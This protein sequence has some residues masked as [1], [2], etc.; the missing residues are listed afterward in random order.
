M[1]TDR[2][3]DRRMGNCLIDDHAAHLRA[4]GKSERTIE[5]RVEVL[6]RLNT[7]LPFGLAFAATEQIEAWLALP[8]RRGKRR[9]R[10]TTI[11][12]GTHIRG[13]YAWADR[14]G[15]LVGDP[16]MLIGR[17][18]NPKSV[19]KPVTE[20]E[21]ERALKS[22]DPW[23]VAVALAAFAGLRA[24]EIAR[25]RREHVTE[26]SVSVL[27]KG[28][29]PGSVPT[30]AYLW[31][32]VVDRPAGLFVTDRGKPVTGRW[33]SAHARH[34]FDAIGLPEV[35]MHRFRHWYGTT[36]Q[37]LT[38]DIR[39]T[40]ECMRHRQVSSTQGYTLVTGAQR[41]AAVAGLPVPGRASAGI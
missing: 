2:E 31:S 1:I 32:V 6:R 39:I 28:E 5:A 17:P 26:D 35:T 23:F 33:I 22:D 12:F 29:D 7:Y 19:P 3:H 18:P 21:L 30:H 41:T 4:A 8:T 13:F 10:W 16:A 11:T 25:A 24:D 34:H 38:G 37:R 20:D 27:G 15:L 40:Q 36:I 9:S 14:A